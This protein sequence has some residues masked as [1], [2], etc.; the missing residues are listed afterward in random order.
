MADRSVAAAAI[1]AD[2]LAAGPWSGGQGVARGCSTERFV[3][4]K[5]PSE[6]DGMAN[7]RPRRCTSPPAAVQYAL[8]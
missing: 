6:R 7:P 8:D 2:G 5:G 3:D 4:V 1:V